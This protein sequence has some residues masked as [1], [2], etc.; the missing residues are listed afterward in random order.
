MAQSKEE[1]AAYHKAY[2]EA[3]KEKITATK[4]A[5]YEANKEKITANK[6]AYYKANKERREAYDKAYYEANKE[7]KAANNK[8]YYEANKERREANKEKIA[9]TK[10]AYREA[11]KEKTSAYSKAYYEDNMCKYSAYSSKRRA[12]KLKLIPKHL[13]NCPVEKQR[14]L[15]IFK[16]STLIS[17]ATGVK[18][19]VD[20]MWPLYD[21]GP[22]WSGNLQIITAHENM[23]KHTSVDLE[24]KHNIQQSLKETM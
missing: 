18:H 12:L 8:A 21:G 16:L 10:K 22:H 1:K 3:N 2:C 9:A 17:K 15:D 7:K 19:H 6:K 24:V 20:H 13:K 23:S 14:V 5:Y 11:N 4:K